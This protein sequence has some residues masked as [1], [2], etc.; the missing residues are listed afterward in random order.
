MSAFLKNLPVKVLGGTGVYL[1][2]ATHPPLHTV[3]VCTVYLFSP[4]WDHGGKGEELTREK[5]SGAM[6]HKAGRKYHHA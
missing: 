3:Y 4:G 6:L 2:E 5:V 1:S